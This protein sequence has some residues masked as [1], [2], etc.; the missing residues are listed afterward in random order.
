MKKI[1]FLFLAV[2]GLSLA[3]CSTDEPI[4][5]AEASI[6]KTS[7]AFTTETPNSTAGKQVKKPSSIPDWV[8]GFKV[9][10]TSTV[11]TNPLYS[12][13]ADFTFDQTNGADN[14]I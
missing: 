1:L 8:N 6:K 5:G 2:I 9:T 14:R 13:F 4:G 12:T 7:V 3:S 10:A 11:Y